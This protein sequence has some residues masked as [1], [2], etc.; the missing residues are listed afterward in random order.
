MSRQTARRA[1]ERRIRNGSPWHGPAPETLKLAE[2]G[3]LEAV[4]Q[5]RNPLPHKSEAHKNKLTRSVKRTG[6]GLG[7]LSVYWA[8]DG[9]VCIDGHHRLAAYQREELTE[10]PVEVFT[11]TLAEAV[12]KALASNTEDKLP[13]DDGEKTAAAWDFTTTWPEI[14]KAKVAV[15]A[16]VSTSTVAN[17]RRVRDGLIAERPYL[18]DLSEFTWRQAQEL[19]K[20]NEVEPNAGS[21]EARVRRIV[22]ALIKAFGVGGLSRDVTLTLEALRAY[23]ED[24][25]GALR[26]AVEDD[27][28]ADAEGQQA[29]DEETEGALAADR[30]PFPGTAKETQPGDF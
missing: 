18:K 19:A 7:R 12:A 5:Y 9:W 17:M 21:R 3:T 23:D 4:F 28:A 22:D 13:M 11:G 6:E 27:E 16:G 24:L 29:D 14:S 8:G 20:G 26:Q 30:L 10:V 25:P 15:E 2:V 1:L